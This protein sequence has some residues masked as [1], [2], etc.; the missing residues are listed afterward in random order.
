ML[1][2]ISK[3]IRTSCRDVIMEE[4]HMKEKYEIKNDELV[5]KAQNLTGFICHSQ[6]YLELMLGARNVY[7][8]LTL[9]ISSMNAHHIYIQ[10]NTRVNDNIINQNNTHIFPKI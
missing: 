6:A 4:T 10:P 7:K 5:Y 2:V 9:G 3:I 8:H 1:N